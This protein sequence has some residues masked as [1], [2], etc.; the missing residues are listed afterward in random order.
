MTARETII[1]AIT[2]I[3]LLATPL[4]AGG[5][6]LLIED[7][8]LA[9]PRG[10]SLSDALPFIIVGGLILCALACGGSDDAP[11]KVPGPVCKEGC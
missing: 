1:A 6:V 5:P 9:E 11:V 7:A 2:G 8:E 3:S 10:Q 4:A